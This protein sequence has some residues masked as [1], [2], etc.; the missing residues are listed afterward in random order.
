MLKQPELLFRLIVQYC[1]LLMTHHPRTIWTKLSQRR[2]KFLFHIRNYGYISAHWCYSLLQRMDCLETKFVTGDRVLCS[3]KLTSSAGII[4]I[5]P[6][7][8]PMNISY[9]HYRIDTWLYKRCN[10]SDPG[11]NSMQRRAFSI[12]NIY[13]KTVNIYSN[14]IC[15][16]SPRF[17]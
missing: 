6:V 4:R 12:R 16:I 17:S 15:G 13:T 14:D 5:L 1:V 10:D 2:L 11:E 9:K 7:S 8:V 3:P